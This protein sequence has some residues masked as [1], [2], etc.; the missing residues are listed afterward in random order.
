MFEDSLIESQHRVSSSNQRWTTALSITL[1]CSIAA[2]IIALPLLHPEALPFHIDAPSVTLPLKPI[3]PPI[4]HV[5]AASSASSAASS[6]SI[7]RSFTEPTHI[8]KL[9]QTPSDTPP[10][11]I[12]IGTGMGN[13]N[14]IADA[15]ATSTSGSGLHVSVA[16]TN[17]A[18]KGPLHISTGVSAGLL[19][20]PITP[21][22]PRIG[23][24]ARAEGTVRVE[25]IISK[26]G[27]IESAHVVSGPD[28]LR[29]AALD[30]IRNAHYSPYLLNGTAIEVETSITVNFK[31]LS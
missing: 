7:S 1:Q 19:L 13:P 22:Y 12:A 17:P 15:F 10:S 31:L 8:P 6:S 21:I 11:A 30:A 24:S 25:A 3:P 9:G 23:I 29:Q 2:A 16:P 27:R 26:S 5:E 4:P 14:G 18:A 20:A 28:M